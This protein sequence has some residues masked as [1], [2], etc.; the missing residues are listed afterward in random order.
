MAASQDTARYLANLKDERNSATLYRAMAGQ[1]KNPK[2]AEVY[3]KL[4]ETEDTHA[5]KWQAKVRRSNRQSKVQGARAFAL[6]IA[7][8]MLRAGAKRP[9]HAGVCLNLRTRPYGTHSNT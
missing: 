5:E 7:C 9:T 2:I 4:A 1:E 3:R 6:R 8:C